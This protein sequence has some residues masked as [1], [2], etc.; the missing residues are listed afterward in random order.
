MV[1]PNW[2]LI[3]FGC[4]CVRSAAQAY[5]FRC[6]SEWSSNSKPWMALEP[7]LVWMFTAAA[8]ASPCSASKELVTTLMVSI[9]SS[10]G[11]Y[12]GYVPLKSVELVPSIRVLF[13]QPLTPLKTT[14]TARDGLAAH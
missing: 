3:Y 6:W 7:V 14:C 5:A 11:V 8:L 12:M 1:P 13:P 9:D 10:A 4:D 2:L